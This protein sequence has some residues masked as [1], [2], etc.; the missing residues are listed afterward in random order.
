MTK[1]IITHY[2][3]EFKE[4]SAKLAVD[5]KE[6]VAQIAKNPQAQIL[7]AKNPLSS[8]LPNYRSFLKAD[9][10]SCADFVYLPTATEKLFLF[11]PVR[12]TVI[13]RP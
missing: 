13:F 11:F 1:R 5:S 6:F 8:L 10:Y 2:P 7:D 9:R 4:S 12:D 3:T